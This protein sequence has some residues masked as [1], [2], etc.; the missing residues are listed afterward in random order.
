MQNEKQPAVYILASRY[1]GTLYVGVTTELYH[2]IHH[3]KNEV[4]QGFTKDYQIKNLVWYAHL[5]TIEEAIKVEKQ[6]KAWKRQ[7]KFEIVEKMNPDWLDLHES[8]DGNFMYIP[9]RKAGP[10][11]SLG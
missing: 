4:F 2:R 6:I 8:I 5:P 9:P 7:W 1:R 3:H 11:L 10:Q